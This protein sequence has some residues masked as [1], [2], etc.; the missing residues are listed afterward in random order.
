MKLV[1]NKNPDTYHFCE[2]VT[3]KEGNVSRVKAAYGA[4]ANK[5]KFSDG[6]S[7]K[8]LVITLLSEAAMMEKLGKVTVDSFPVVGR[9]VSIKD[10]T[11][12]P[13]Q[14]KSIPCFMGN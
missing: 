3:A 11:I 4:A 1:K 14:W 2:L 12:E 13:R 8:K 10:L 6:R 7:F 5:L 9:S